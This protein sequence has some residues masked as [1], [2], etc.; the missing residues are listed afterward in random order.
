MM[1]MMA[2]NGPRLGALGCLVL[3][4]AQAGT[5][6]VAAGSTVAALPPMGYNSWNDLETKPTEQKIKDIVRASLCPPVCAAKRGDVCVCV[7]VCVGGGG[8]GGGGAHARVSVRCAT[9]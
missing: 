8:G 6:R 9:S 7:C 3:A 5:S 2:G 1:I 4:W